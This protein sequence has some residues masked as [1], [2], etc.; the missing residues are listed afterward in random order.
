MNAPD[1]A[2]AKTRPLLLGT[3]AAKPPIDSIKRRMTQTTV[4]LVDTTAGAAC[5]PPFPCDSPM[6]LHLV[7]DRDGTYS[8]H[9]AH[10][11][12]LKVLVKRA[13]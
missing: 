9:I 4:E 7:Q 1:G 13:N 3:L 6:E 8:P 5:L 11:K 10:C 2:C 12:S